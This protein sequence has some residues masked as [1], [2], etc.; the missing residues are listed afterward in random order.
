MTGR[1]SHGLGTP[2]ESTSDRHFAVD[3]GRCI[4]NST[5]LCM[6]TCMATKTISV[7][8]EAYEQLR[9][10]R[11]TER[12]SF[13]QVIKRAVWMPKQGTAGRLLATTR[14]SAG[15]LSD[16]QLDRLDRAQEMDVEAPDRWRET[17]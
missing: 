16:E 3:R 4:D 15:I 5:S 9:R 13:S 10:A 1:R 17:D 7:D 8:L 11:A 2:Q 14:A 6:Y 12:E